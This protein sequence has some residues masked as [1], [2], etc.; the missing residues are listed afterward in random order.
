MTPT[1][2]RVPQ[3]HQHT[4]ADTGITVGIRK[5]SPLIQADIRAAVDHDHPRPEPPMQRV[6]TGPDTWQ[7]VPNPADPAYLAALGVWQREHNQRISNQLLTYA[8]ERAIDVEVDADAVAELRADMAARGV[9]LSGRSDK[10]V[11]VCYVCI[12]SSD[13]LQELSEVVFNRSRPS[14]EAIAAQKATFPDHVS[15][16]AAGGSGGAPATRADPSE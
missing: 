12:G 8:A 4:I 14:A 9:D 10:Y 11:Y 6:E 15:G 3:L 2:R 1:G 16:A 7:S 5:V 13:D